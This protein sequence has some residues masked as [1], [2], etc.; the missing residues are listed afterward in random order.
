MFS[1]GNAKTDT[2]RVY[3][4]AGAMHAGFAQCA[5]FDQDAIDI[6]GVECAFKEAGEDQP[7]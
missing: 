7:W 6:G 4:R 5:A 2:Q 3:A 1:A